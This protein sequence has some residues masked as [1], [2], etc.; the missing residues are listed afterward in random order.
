MNEVR[1]GRPVIAGVSTINP[2]EAAAGV[3]IPLHAVVV[4]GLEYR[5]G[6]LGLKIYDPVG[7]VYWE[8]L[9]TFDQFFTGEFVKPI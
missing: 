6:V 5:A 7:F 1:A 8:R 2:G 4:E 9:S 3:Q